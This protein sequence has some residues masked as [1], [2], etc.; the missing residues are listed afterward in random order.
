MIYFDNGDLLDCNC[1]YICHQVNCQGKMNSGVAKAIREKWPVV[2]TKYFDW[3]VGYE[4]WASAHENAEYKYQPA[5]AMLGSIQIVE[6]NN[7]QKVINMAAQN[8]YGYDGR[9]YTSYDAFW[10]CLG[11]IKDTIPK[12]SKI[13]FPDHIGCCRGGANWNVILA[14]IGEVLDKDYKVHIIYKEDEK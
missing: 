1:Q 13:A 9:R 5:D 8:G 2:Y 3:Y 14:M 6:V 10:S 4:A 7:E 11:K 12:G